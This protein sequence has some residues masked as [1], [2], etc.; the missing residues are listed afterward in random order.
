MAPGEGV[1]FYTYQ[2][3]LNPRSVIRGSLSMAGVF[4]IVSAVNGSTITVSAAVGNVRRMTIGSGTRVIVVG[5]P[6]ATVDDI[7]PGVKIL[8]LGVRNGMDSLEPLAVIATPA[9]YT[10]ANVVVGKLKS[11][12]ADSMSLETAA[13]VVRVD[14]PSD[15]EIYGQRLL[16]AQ[17][18]DL[19]A[20]NY[21]IV[22]GQ[23]QSDGTMNA[24]VVLSRTAGPGVWQ[25]GPAFG[26]P[27]PVPSQ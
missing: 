23:P 6:Q 9:G 11:R 22:I 12:T 20:G 8:M 25:R 10:K 1:I 13:G 2:S 18:S 14:L 21:V 24:Q 15:A 19:V 4:G 3:A 16:P 7:K 26:D 17:A 27:T 5:V